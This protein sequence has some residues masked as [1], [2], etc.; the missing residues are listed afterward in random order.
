[1]VTAPD[2]MPS[3]EEIARAIKRAQI[4]DRAELSKEG[5]WRDFELR[6]ARAVL[7]LFAPI[8]AEK[9]REIRAERLMTQKM[10][11]LAARL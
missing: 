5:P 7:A 10:R 6:Y 2:A 11:E 1:M 3:E 4:G 9:E 8:L